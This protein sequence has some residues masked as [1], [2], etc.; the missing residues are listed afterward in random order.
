M[1]EAL[2]S[3]PLQ[4]KCQKEEDATPHSKQTRR[5]LTSLKH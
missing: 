4:R 1:E 2:F 3:D 5:Q